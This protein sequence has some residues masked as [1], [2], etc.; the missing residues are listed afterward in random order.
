MFY[1]LFDVVLPPMLWPVVVVV[2][3]L[4]SSDCRVAIATV[5]MYVELVSVDCWVLGVGLDYL[6]DA[7]INFGDNIIKII[8]VRFKLPG[9]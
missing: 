9:K 1:C 7:L 6:I 2:L 8:K 5:Y 4:A 3:P